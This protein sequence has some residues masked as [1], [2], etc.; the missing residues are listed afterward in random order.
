MKKTNE[1]IETFIELRAM[2]HSFRKISEKMN[3]S[4][5]TLIQWAKDLNTA[6]ANRQEIIFEDLRDKYA[7]TKRAKI[8]AFGELLGKIRDEIS[9]REN[10]SDVPSEKL[11]RLF[12]D[13]FGKIEGEMDFQL[14]ETEVFA[15]KN[16][17]KKQKLV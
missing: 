9:L 14:S 15:G 1:N 5:N 11:I 8:Q 12:I 4:E 2:G 16:F 6:I 17:E 3:I 10:L 7:M 13:V